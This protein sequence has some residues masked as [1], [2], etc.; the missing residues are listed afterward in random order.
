M[1]SDSKPT[2][3]PCKS[4]RTTTQDTFFK[5]YGSTVDRQ[6]WLTKWKLQ[7]Q[8]MIKWSSF[9]LAIHNTN[10]PL[11]KKKKKAFII[12]SGS[13]ENYSILN[14]SMLPIRSIYYFA[15]QLPKWVEHISPFYKSFWVRASANSHQS[16][17]LSHSRS[18]SIL[19]NPRLWWIDMRATTLSVMDDENLQWKLHHNTPSLLPSFSFT[20]MKGQFMKGYYLIPS[21]IVQ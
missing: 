17:L 16:C 21:F 18:H 11:K 12:F 14:Q 4:H 3:H 13:L 6:S 19:T 20:L 7:T 15:S 10:S 2:N 1:H 8:L 5:C 9:L